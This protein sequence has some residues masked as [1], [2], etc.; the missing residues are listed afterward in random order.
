MQRGSWGL[1]KGAARV[2]ARR[3]AQEREDC[4]LTRGHSSFIMKGQNIGGKPSHA[5]PVDSR[6][7]ALLAAMAL[8]LTGCQ[9][10]I[11]IPVGRS[12]RLGRLS[13]FDQRGQIDIAEGS[14]LSDPPRAA[15][16]IWP[17][18]AYRISRR[19]LAQLLAFNQDRYVPFSYTARQAVEMGR[20]PSLSGRGAPGATTR[21]WIRRWPARTASR[22][23][24]CW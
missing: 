10:E 6:I 5:A 7:G 13:R 22:E 4:S 23:R 20:H 8:L 2:L 11:G 17:L 18:A 21:W 14:S 9:G 16:S 24:I 12:G 15:A 3:Q 19:Q 1:N